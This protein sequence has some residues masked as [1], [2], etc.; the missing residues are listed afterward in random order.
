MNEPAGEGKQG[1]HNESKDEF[2]PAAFAPLHE[3]LIGVMAFEGDQKT[4][5]KKAPDGKG[6]NDAWF[7]M[8]QR[9]HYAN[10]AICPARHIVIR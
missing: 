6:D 3:P 1:D 2:G 4:Q 5:H 8:E 7:Y 10:V 9:P